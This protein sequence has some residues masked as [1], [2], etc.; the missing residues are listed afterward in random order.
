MSYSSQDWNLWKAIGQF[1]EELY[2]NL[3]GSRFRSPPRAAQAAASARSRSRSPR[4]V[5]ARAAL[6]AADR[7]LQRYGSPSR[8]GQSPLRGRQLSRS[9]PRGRPGAR[10]GIYRPPQ[11]ARQAAVQPDVCLANPARIVSSYHSRIPSYLAI[12]TYMKNADQD[13]IC[14]LNENVFPCKKRIGS[15]SV[16]GMVYRL[17]NK[18]QTNLLPTDFAVKVME[19]SQRNNLLEVKN[20]QTYTRTVLQK[21]MPH[22][23][24]C[25]TDHKCKDKCTFIDTNGMKDMETRMIWEDVKQGD[26]YMMF[27][28]LFHGDMNHFQE[29]LTGKSKIEQTKILLSFVAQ[30]FVAAAYLDRY[31]LSH[32]D[33]HTGNLLYKEISDQPDSPF[34]YNLS[35]NRSLSICHQSYLFA[36]WDVAFIQPK[37]RQD[38]ARKGSGIVTGT[39]HDLWT[40]FSWMKEHFNPNKPNGDDD[41]FRLFHALSKYCERLHEIRDFNEKHIRLTIENVFTTPEEYSR[42]NGFISL[43][44]IMEKLGILDVWEEVVQLDNRHIWQD[45]GN[46]IQVNSDGESL[47]F[48]EAITEQFDLTDLS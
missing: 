2:P 19:A 42:L 29:N 20:A 6:T 36:M 10:Q 17:Y 47:P 27:M 15:E 18:S 14:A 21:E 44:K 11:Q 33:L 43:P 45:N 22:F 16:Y 5:S 26:C 39:F 23:V 1:G 28:E 9:P 40:L 13:Q 37:N 48:N 12:Q 8:A 31:N 7:Y 4:P 3:D 38:K 30:V 25:W 46:W 34:I 41:F 24:M 35:K 32:N